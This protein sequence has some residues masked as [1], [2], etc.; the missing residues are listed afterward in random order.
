MVNK[1]YNM[2][3]V[4]EIRNKILFTLAMLLVFRIG[5]AIPAPLVDST[6]VLSGLKDNTLLGMMNVLGGGALEKFSIFA[7]G[8]GPYITASII[9]ELLSMDVIPY[10]TE[11]AKSGMQG[12][13]KKDKITRYFAVLLSFF[14]A[15]T[16][17]Y[18][19]D[20]N[21]GILK[22]QG[23]YNFFYVSIVLTAGTMFLM[24][25]GDQISVKGIGNGIS[26]IIFA[27]IVA[28][29]PWQFVQA[30]NTMVDSSS[31]QS[32]FNGI[33]NFSGYVVVYL[34]IILLVVLMQIAIR[35]IPIQ[36]TSS[37]ISRGQ[38]DITFLP[39]RINSASVIPVIFASS[40][41]MAPVT[42]MSFF[43][44]NDI[45]TKISQVLDFRQPLGLTIYAILI[46]LFT[47]FYTNLQVDPEK[48]AENLGKSGAYI[49]GIRPG[50]E[51]IDYLTKVIN[52]ITVFGAIFI[53][54][55]GILP[56]LIPLVTTL[57]SSISVGGTGL[58]IVVGV[59]LETYKDL[60]G[61]MTQREYR[62]FNR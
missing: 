20:V 62:G 31:N 1:I 53:T 34:L 12:R 18:A 8:I 41:M 6:K 55:I 23:L 35:K 54:C 37:S 57:P 25:L 47:F 4:K 7:M 30:F 16:L 22:E 28:N 29:M 60:E 36:Y 9:I 19:F 59:A 49:P 45:M 26:M 50:K 32:I 39:L 43:S 15:F 48:I 17:T 2:L 52:R 42:V 27:G 56:H 44:T 5:A 38:R 14:Q 10:L 58:I 61:Q 21:Y 3:K 40:I 13:M 24:W 33:L 46:V 11:L 51:T